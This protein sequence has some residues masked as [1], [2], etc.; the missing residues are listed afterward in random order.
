MTDVRPLPHRLGRWL[1]ALALLPLGAGCTWALLDILIKS[2]AAV[3]FWLT[4]LGGGACWL[5]V[6]LLL[7]K[8]MWLYVVGHEMTHALTAW[9]CGGKVK[10]LKAGAEG[11]QVV[12]TK[13]NALIALA[14]YFLPLYSLL[15]ALVWLGIRLV[16]PEIG[17]TLGFH[18]G[19]G[20]TYAFHLT[21]TAHI[22]RIRQ[23]DIIGEGRV[24]SAMVI[25][26]GNTLTLLFA[27]PLLTDQYR[28]LDALIL[29]GE[30]TGQLL[31]LAVKAFQHFSH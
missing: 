14:P 18:F 26:L 27:V 31:S 19:I 29:V 13:T 2:R 10:S 7:P 3:D 25:W 1:I 9:L 28:L 16:W 11:G 8:P 22:L 30:R 5:V 4:L 6:F 12:L 23:P 20:V 15:W 21:L 17:F 24:F